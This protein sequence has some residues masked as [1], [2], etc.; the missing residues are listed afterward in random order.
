MYQ[1][2]DKITWNSKLFQTCEIKTAI[3]REKNS[4]IKA[5]RCS[6]QT[7]YLLPAPIYGLPSEYPTKEKWCPVRKKEWLQ[8]LSLNS[9]ASPLHHG[10]QAVNTV[11]RQVPVFLYCHI[12]GNHPYR[13]ACRKSYDISTCSK[14]CVQFLWV[15]VW[16]YPG[17]TFP[18]LSVD[19][20]RELS[21]IAYNNSAIRYRIFW[22]TC[23]SI[24]SRPISGY[25]NLHFLSS[26]A[27]VHRS[28]LPGDCPCPVPFW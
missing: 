1:V 7:Q 12:Q 21:V 19:W 17:Y 27:T 14:D 4:T 9:G 5:E 13:P 15:E 16:R 24:D 28:R 2:L 8:E 25:W 6:L 18:F 22:Q 26:T 10:F 11:I 23:A 3:Q 20:L